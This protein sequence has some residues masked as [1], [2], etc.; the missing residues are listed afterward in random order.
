M[1]QKK[2]SANLKARGVEFIQS[3]EQQQK[4]MK[5]VR[6]ASGTSGLSSGAIIF[7][8]G[9]REGEKKETK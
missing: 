4:V 3:E 7:I 2:R 1:K 5:R 9:I 6:I 8:T